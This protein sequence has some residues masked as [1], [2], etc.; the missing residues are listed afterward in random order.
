MNKVFSKD[1]TAIAFDR[2]GQE[3]PIILVDGAPCSRA[4]G[5]MPQL[6]PLLAPRF[7]VYHYDRRGRNDSGD[8]A[9]Y[10]VEREIEDLEAL[11]DEA[12]GSAFV[13][14]TS[15]GAALA[16]AAAARGL[17]IE[18]LALYEP[19]FMVDESGR[20]PPADHQT[21]LRQLIA[22]GRRGD[23]LRFFMTRV[24]GM[25][26]LF[27]WPM[28]L[29]PMWSKLEAVAHTLPYDA[30]VKAEWS[31]SRAEPW[32]LPGPGSASL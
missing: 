19:P 6:A 18:K 26:A 3:R 27:V 20:R 24:V 13:Y 16:L 32:P 23:A 31:T 29:M 9:P 22:S 1:G 14:G 15:S 5:P 2:S 8:T 4:F 21:Q 30:A 28:R 17:K 10:A 25:P 11:I 7:T 12:G